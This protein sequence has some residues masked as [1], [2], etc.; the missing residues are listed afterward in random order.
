MRIGFDMLAV[1]SPHHG[2]RGIGRYSRHL[3]AAP[4]KSGDGHQFVLYAHDGLPDDRI[5]RGPNATVRW[6]GPESAHDGARVSHRV[7]R[8]ARANPDALDV[9][10]VLSPFELW[11][12]YHPPARPRDGLKLA[13]IVYD[14]IPFLH[15]SEGAHDPNLMRSYRT[16]EE[17]RRYD[18]LLAISDASRDDCIR[19]LGLPEHQRQVVTIG[20][21]SD[22]DFFRP[23]APEARSRPSAA[24]LELGITRPFLLNV[25]G[26]DWRKN[27]LGLIDAFERLPGPL[28]DAHQLVMTFTV[29][30]ED[31][32][33]LRRYAA[34]AGVGDALVVTGEVSDS[35][36]LTLYQHCAA[37]AFPSLYEGFGL[38]L[39][40][41]ML[42]GAPVV[43]GNNSSQPEVVGD[44][45]LLVDAADPADLAAKLGTILRDPALA[46]TLRTRALDQAM[47][48]RWE[49]VAGR[50]AAVLTDL[51]GRRPPARFRV[52]RGH[53]RKPR[54]AFFS[55]FPPRKS[56]VS[57]YSTL[58][59]QELKQTYTIDLFHDSSYVPELGLTSDAF[60]CINY[61]L[62]ETV[63]RAKDYRAVV[64]Q[65][66]NSH[67]H[68]FMYETLLAHPGV[69]TLHD[70]CL[71]GFYL[72]YG[73]KLGLGRKLIQDEL[74]AWYPGRADEIEAV[75]ASTPN[76]DLAAE[77]TRRGWYLNL[78][79]LGTPSRV[80]VHSPWCVERVR[81]THP[82][83]AARMAV[84]PHGMRSRQLS[85][86]ERAAIRDRFG[87]PRAALMI[88]SFGFIHPDKMSTE[89]L[90]AFL[91]VA[92]ADGSALFAFVGEDADGG[93]VRRHASALGLGD[94]VRFLGRRS[95][96][97]FADLAAVTDLGVN[98]RRPPTNGE[99]SGAL[100]YL[101]ASGVATIVTDVGTFSDYPD[102]VVRKVGWESGGLDGLRRAVLE[103]A[104]DPRA[105]AVLGRAARE[106][107]RVHHEWPHVAE[108]YVE[109][110]ERWYAERSAARERRRCRP[111]GAAHPMAS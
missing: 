33:M 29:L 65:M 54:I 51:A 35:T 95:I 94:R 5:P 75:M 39:L 69:M 70:F 110:I 61:R 36:L 37:F 6:L 88:A 23:V 73:H 99:T 25:G 111:L 77:C 89:A 63:A 90:D 38:P 49:R 57:D 40:E 106:H 86:G 79:L 21:A 10:V 41:A 31:A 60:E 4:L 72:H 47:R 50:A 45:G 93:V 48:F 34:E 27:C 44:A 74:L 53:A 107:V 58:L 42:C 66:G 59:I 18:A 52:D 101:L 24:L 85:E 43:A 12:H 46:E 16:L 68:N 55:P 19:L 56:G 8:L 108:M 84:I 20:A 80:V 83:H 3:V 105:R 82:E 92:R 100:L 26:M 98:L 7:D 11:Q 32:A 97:D 1:Q 67:Y 96:A 103:L 9:L 17:L 71:A 78:R 64:Y 104:A 15:Q 2:H 62:F 22:P 102:D 30:P 91:E 87:I 81:A 14:M 28:R 109:V 13:A 76:G